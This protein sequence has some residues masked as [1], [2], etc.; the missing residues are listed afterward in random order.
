VKIA[1]TGANGFVGR[2][3]CAELARRKL[4]VLAL[5]RSP[6]AA[7]IAVAEQA[8]ARDTD[9]EGALSRILA[10]SD[11]LVHL[12]ARV[13]DTR[14][15]TR[16]ETYFSVNRDYS[17]RL[18]RAALAAGVKRFV[19]LSTIKVNGEHTP[20]DQPF[21]E[22]SPARPEGAYAES[23]WQAEQGLAALGG[24]MSRVIVRCP[25][26]YGPGVRA[27]FAR[28]LH[29]VWRGWPL[30]FGGVHNQRSLIYVGNLAHALAQ[31]SLAS[32]D[33][34]QT[35]TYLVADGE[36]LSTPELVRKL[37]AALGV[38]ARLV[39]VPLP[40]LE[41]VFAAAGKREA[42]ARLV[43]SLRVSSGRLRSEHG[44]VPPWSVEQGLAEAARWF[45]EGR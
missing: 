5:Q 24:E 26:V 38:R 28:L 44:W 11:A 14:G 41:L 36:D 1:V 7:N 23:K 19:F 10:G 25:L 30:P 39:P 32:L 33:R 6:P 37:A 16:A 40:V 43:G 8:L 13:H 3:L 31:L 18:A 35:H 27:N 42:L 12:A 17:L 20:L 4:R 15:A 29:A 45:Q 9:D 21:S 22:A 2:A 34:G